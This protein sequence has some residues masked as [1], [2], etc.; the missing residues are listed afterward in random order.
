MRTYSEIAEQA[1]VTYKTATELDALKKAG[2]ELSATV[3]DIRAQGM[4][5]TDIGQ[6]CQSLL[7]RIKTK[8]LFLGYFHGGYYPDD[9]RAATD[10]FGREKD[11]AAAKGWVNTAA[12][13]E[14]A[15]KYIEEVDAI[16]FDAAALLDSVRDR[17]GD[18]LT[19]SKT[20]LTDVANKFKS[21]LSAAAELPDPKE[22]FGPR[23]KIPKLVEQLV[24]DIQ[25]A[26]SWCDKRVE[27]IIRRDDAKFFEAHTKKPPEVMAPMFYPS[28]MPDSYT[29][30]SVIVLN[31]PFIDE[32]YLALSAYSATCSV[33]FRVVAGGS[34]S[35]MTE[36]D[37][38]RLFGVFADKK[39]GLIVEELNDY[40][41]DDIFD[42]LFGALI[43]LGKKG[44][45]VFVT[46]SVGDRGVYDRIL[47]FV[48]GADGYSAL[49][50]SNVFLCMPSCNE[51]MLALANNKI[52]EHGVT[53][54]YVRTKMK[55]S[56][57]VGLNEVIKTAL[58]GGSWRNAGLSIS[59]SREESARKYLS[60]LPSQ[61]QLLDLGWGEEEFNRNVDER[62]KSFD[63]D[64]V[65]G[66]DPDN[67]RRI[68]ESSELNIFERCGGAA[69]YCTLGG[70]DQ[71]VWATIPIEEREARINTAT[72][73]VSRSLS[74]SYTPSVRIVTKK[75]MDERAGKA[76]G[77]C[78]DGGKEIWYREDCCD[79]IDW[80]IRAICHECFH[81]FQHTAVDGGY[82]RW[83]FTE[84]GVTEGRID[85]WKNNFSMY[86]GDVDS[87]TYKVE[88]VESDAVAFEKDCAGVA[89]KALARVR[90]D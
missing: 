6:D 61:L 43:S 7:L 8:I 18:A 29:T 80:L 66:V 12:V 69:L 51:Y 60:K 13:M 14:R 2:V 54:E 88:I 5:D 79:N 4:L 86:D 81:S 52:I 16:M 46:D 62:K 53:D 28:V 49:D 74:T 55:F 83:Y 22:V 9:K 58:S 11:K 76:G 25:E 89:V 10:F 48:N 65:F 34:L 45:K 78:V 68:V 84:L 40:R 57:Y 75:E 44:V 67:I 42:F 70:M 77:L 38:K 32:A 3:K 41:N 59:S 19:S 33:E 64:D 72:Q 1:N 20:M 35:S 15:E 47:D 31:T 82:K 63:Y 27:D 24:N 21:K 87:I 17:H 90:L 23:I 26:A 39:I 71:S 56:G 50:V 37:I 36:A 30:A 73:F 85:R